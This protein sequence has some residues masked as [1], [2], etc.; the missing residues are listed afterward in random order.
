VAAVSREGRGV[1]GEGRRAKGEGRAAR[2]CRPYGTQ[3]LLGGCSTKMPRLR[4]SE[5]GADGTDEPTELFGL[6]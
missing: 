3:S 1:R 2:Q 4:R 6:R 5:A